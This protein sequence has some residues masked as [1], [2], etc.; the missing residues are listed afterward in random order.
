MPAVL[1]D[2]HK[3]RRRDICNFFGRLRA[4]NPRVFR[5]LVTMDESWVYTWDPAL[6]IHNKEWLRA[7]EDR[8]LVPRKTIATA[9]VMLVAFYDSRGMVYYEY[10]QRPQTVNQQT[11]RAIFRRFDAAHHR[12][13]PHAAVHGRR[14]LHMDNAPAHNAALTLGLVTQLGWT[15]LPQPAYSPDL[16]PCDFWLFSRLKRNLRG[17]RFRTLADLKEAVSEE[18]ALIPAQEYRH[19]IMVSWPR[20]WRSCLQQQGNYFEGLS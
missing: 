14:F 18:I 7:G 16:A 8:P 10:V 19:S 2:H 5:N 12:R 11:F 20:R 9:K 1:T 15:R 4:Q 13:R 3:A 17:V 6:R